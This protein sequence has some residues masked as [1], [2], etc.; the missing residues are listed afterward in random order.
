MKLNV[1]LTSYNRPKL[2]EMAIDSLL[3]QT[4]DRWH[5]YIQDDNSKQMTVNVVKGFEGDDRFTIG[6]HNT[7]E[8]ERQETTRYSVLINEILPD[9]K[10][11]VVCTMCD[12][13]EY[14]PDLVKTVLDWFKDNPKAKSA[15]V[16]QTRDFF[17]DEDAQ[18]WLG[19]ANAYGH[20]MFMP[21]QP[22]DEI[23][24]PRG[25]LDHSQVFHRLPVTMKWN[26]KR[27]VVA[28]G[29]ADFFERMVEKYGPIRRITTEPLSVEHLIYKRI[30]G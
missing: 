28:H 14:Y 6:T 1:I 13:V 7:S 25:Q 22:Y 15:Y 4:D 18:E 2:L 26:E 12:N 19:W 23:S 30:H 24:N 21:N 5:C 9:L 10:D 11:G 20:W 29:D 8:K 3:A 17:T 16:P 27:D